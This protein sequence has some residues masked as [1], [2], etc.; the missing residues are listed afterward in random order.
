ME[1]KSVS[2]FAFVLAAAA[3]STFVSA[4]LD[5]Q[6]TD[7]SVSGAQ[8]SVTLHNPASVDETARVQV[9][10]SEVGGGVETL[11][12]A[13]TTFAAGTTQAVTLT[14]SHAIVGITEYPEPIN[15]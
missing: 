2:R 10:V 9:T 7:V 15:P 8:I 4:A 5:L 14:A 3:L 6:V 11:Q 12:S 1:K 13:S